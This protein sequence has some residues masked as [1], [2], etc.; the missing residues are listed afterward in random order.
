MYPFAISL[1]VGLSLALL[2]RKARHETILPLTDTENGA[3]AW[4]KIIIV[5]SVPVLILW[6]MWRVLQSFPD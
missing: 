6:M 2:Y 4:L 5:A 3:T 1:V